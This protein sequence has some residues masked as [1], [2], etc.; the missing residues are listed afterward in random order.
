MST[1][2]VLT[3]FGVYLHYHSKLKARFYYV[4]LK[5][6]HSNLNLVI[7][8]TYRTYPN[9]KFGFENVWLN[10]L[11]WV[12]GQ[13]KLFH[14]DNFSKITVKSSSYSHRLIQTMTISDFAGTFWE[15]ILT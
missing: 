3:G 11:R 10:T 6:S 2:F 8:E 7:S 12:V 14:K 1:P 15:G 9:V 13:F 5:L 4:P